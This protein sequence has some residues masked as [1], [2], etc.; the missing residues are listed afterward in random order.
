MKN[1]WKD[2]FRN[3]GLVEAVW[4]AMKNLWKDLIRNSGLVEAAFRRLQGFLL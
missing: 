4:R 3:S 1:L 2:L